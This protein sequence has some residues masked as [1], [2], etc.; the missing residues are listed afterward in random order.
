MTYHPNFS[1]PRV[2]K[3]AKKSLTFVELYTKETAIAWI[4]VHELYKN[5]GNTSRPLGRWL[6]DKLL[7]TRDSYYNSLTGQCKKYSKNAEGVK[8][9]MAM[10]DQPDFK[11][12]IKS[13]L[14]QQLDTGHIVYEEKS[15]RLFNPLQYIPKRIRNDIL[16]N[17]GYRY[18][19]DIKAAA[20]RLLYQ[21]AQQI[22][23]NLKLVHLEEFINNRSDIRLKIAKDCEITELQAKTVI[24]ALLQGGVISSWRDNKIFQDLNYNYDAIIKLKNNATVMC[25]KEDIKSLWVALREELPV[26][27]ITDKTGKTRRCRVRG[28]DK[29]E[30]YRS[31]EKQIGVVIRGLLKRHKIKALWI[32]DGW[33]CD[34]V[35]DPSVI[36][37]EVRR[38][39]HYLIELDWTIYEE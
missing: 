16:A 26:R 6:K 5:F 35:I 38:K 20:P 2:I 14:L 17:K 32:H 18:H 33:V 3:A 19:Y 11:P 23:P 22:N 15:D 13:E 9:V 36:V 34:E 24:N 10:I 37:T 28:S 21:R 29:S 4:S 8:Q 12:E 7:I 25:L 27:Y 31:L 39:T 30:L 1:D